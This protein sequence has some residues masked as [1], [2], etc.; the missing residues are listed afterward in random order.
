M[1]YVTPG[2]GDWERPLYLRDSPPPPPPASALGAAS[3]G[4]FLPVF[5]Q[6]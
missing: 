4:S 5:Q 6:L 1:G 3:N 2:L